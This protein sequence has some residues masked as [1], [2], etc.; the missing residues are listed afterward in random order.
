MEYLIVTILVALVIFAGKKYPRPAGKN[1]GSTKG[2][3]S[4]K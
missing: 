3:G 4:D 2:T 1:S